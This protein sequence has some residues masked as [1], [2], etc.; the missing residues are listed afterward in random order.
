MIRYV[1]L[2]QT[3]INIPPYPLVAI[4]LVSCGGTPP[5]HTMERPASNTLPFMHILN[6]H[7]LSKVINDPMYHDLI[8]HKILVKL[9]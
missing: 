7:E 9:P 1:V 6:M 4:P 3:F 2:K 5:L 8:W